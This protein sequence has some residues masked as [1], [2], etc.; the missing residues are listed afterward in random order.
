M[1]EYVLSCEQNIYK[2]GTNGK[3]QLCVVYSVGSQVYSSKNVTPYSVKNFSADIDD[4][5]IIHIAVI[6]NDTLT[7]IKF[8]VEKSTTT[9]LMHL[10]QNFNITDVLI[11]V[12]D[13]IKLDYCVS[14]MEGYALIEY[15]FSDNHWS[16]RNI[17]TTH[18]E[19][20]LLCFDSQKDQCYIC[21]KEKDSYKLINA[22]TDEFIISNF[23][24]H[25]AQILGGKPIYSSGNSIFHQNDEISSG[26]SVYVLEDDKIMCCDGETKVMIYS[27]SWQYFSKVKVPADRQE[28]IMCRPHQNKRIIL[29]QPFPHIMPLAQDEFSS[30]VTQEIYH[31]Q[32]TIFSLTSEVRILKS[33]L[34]KL[35]EEFEI[36][37]TRENA[38]KHEKNM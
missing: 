9:H 23:P 24:F 31:Q 28:Y 20:K 6:G 27:G 36:S 25:Y 13:N 38:R 3:G 1:R 4:S 15:T 17:Y 7:Y 14:S 2:V 12:N 18:N 32:K 21:E 30:S 34:R 11:S 5:G 37:K 26:E 22:S 29:S 35:E 16:G 33:K 19:L 8:S 10:P